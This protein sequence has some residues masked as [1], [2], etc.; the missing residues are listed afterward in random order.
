M[1]VDNLLHD[2][3]RLTSITK[4]FIDATEDP[5]PVNRFIGRYEQYRKFKSEFY[6]IKGRLKNICV[7]VT[8]KDSSEFRLDI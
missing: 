3:N 5:Y 6:C 7:L 8:L 2:L 4:W 1:T